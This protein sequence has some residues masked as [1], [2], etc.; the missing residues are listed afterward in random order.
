MSSPTFLL[1]VHLPQGTWL[2]PFF[3]MVYNIF[4]TYAPRAKYLGDINVLETITDGGGKG[5]ERNF[6]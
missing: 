5:K 3:F 4:S 2:G 1:K 6:I